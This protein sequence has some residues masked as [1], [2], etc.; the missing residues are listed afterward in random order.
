MQREPFILRR[1]AAVLI[2]LTIAG[3]LAMSFLSG[4]AATGVARVLNHQ[5]RLYDSGG[6][7]LGGAGTPYCFRFAFYDDDTPGGPDT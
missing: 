5:G 7:L 1:P 2:S 4:R 3:V 6:N